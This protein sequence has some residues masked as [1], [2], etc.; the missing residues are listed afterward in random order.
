MELEVSRE[1]FEKARAAKVR[2][3]ESREEVGAERLAEDGEDMREEVETKV[4]AV[5]AGEIV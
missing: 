4:L 1:K 3:K 5:V 2:R